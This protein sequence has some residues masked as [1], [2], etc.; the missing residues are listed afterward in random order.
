MIAGPPRGAVAPAARRLGFA[1]SAFAGAA[2]TL[3]FAPWEFWWL[4]PLAVGAL[5]ALLAGASPRDAALRGWAFGAG[6][7]TTGLWWIYISL[8]TYGHLPAWLA[9]L[10]VGVLAGLLSLYYAVA[11]WAWARSR[12]GRTTVDAL[13]FA[14]LWLLAELARGEFFTGFPWIAG[15]YAHTCGALAR[16]APYVG[17][18]GLGAISAWI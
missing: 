12:R 9:A 3:S 13:T 18:Y 4:Q 15:G 6:W 16:W 8:H 2:Q 1:L 11:A 10:A 7:L 17:V 5:V 14:A